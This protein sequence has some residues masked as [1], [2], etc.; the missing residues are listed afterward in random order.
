MNVY[1]A[2]PLT[3]VRDEPVPVELVKVPNVFV[4]FLGPGS[5]VP[6]IAGPFEQD[7]A[8]RVQDVL[9]VPVRSVMGMVLIQDDQVGAWNMGGDQAGKELFGN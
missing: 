7:M 8:G 4:G 9:D 2:Q 6:F 3:A 5:I 1:A